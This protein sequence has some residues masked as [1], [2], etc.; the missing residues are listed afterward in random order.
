MTQSE[1]ESLTGYKFPDGW[2]FV[3]ILR[4]GELA[5]F[6][7][8]KGDEIHC[9]RI[10][11]FSGRWLTRQ[12]IERIITPIFTKFC[13]I[14][15]KVRKQNSIGHRFVQRLGF[16]HVAEDEFCIFY[17]ARSINHARH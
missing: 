13:T 4:G 8:T 15:T 1:A 9:H 14:K 12:D 16:S 6:F 3:E 17:E 5:G 2:E 7:C 11:S 10:E